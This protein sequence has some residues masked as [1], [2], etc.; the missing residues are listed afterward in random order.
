MYV[1]YKMQKRATLGKL[2]LRTKKLFAASGGVS[3]N[4]VSYC[5]G[6]L[7]Y[8]SISSC[9]TYNLEIKRN[10]MVTL[11]CDYIDLQNF[12]KLFLNYCI[13]VQEYSLY[14]NIMNTQL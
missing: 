11:N 1:Y 14:V 4:T 13:L 3:T 8:T 12:K 10:H 9:T 2:I 5:R 7:S 6:Q